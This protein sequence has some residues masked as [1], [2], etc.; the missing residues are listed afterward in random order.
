MLSGF[1]D[2]QIALIGCVTALLVCGG[3]MSLSY[4]LRPQ[5]ERELAADEATTVRFPTA[6]PKSDDVPERRAA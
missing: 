3:L 4:Y 1:S 2:D 6:Q 5:G